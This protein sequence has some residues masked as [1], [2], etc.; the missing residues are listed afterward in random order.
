MDLPELRYPEGDRA[1]LESDD[2]EDILAKP[3]SKRFLPFSGARGVC[4]SIEPKLLA[5]LWPLREDMPSELPGGVL[6]GEDMM[7]WAS[8]ESWSG[9]TVEGRGGCGQRGRRDEGSDCKSS[10]AET[11]ASRRVEDDRRHKSVPSGSL[12]RSG[13]ILRWWWLL[14]STQQRPRRSWADRSGEARPL[15]D[16]ESK[17]CGGSWSWSRRGS[18]GAEMGRRE[19]T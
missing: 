12:C 14:P 6:K 16:G 4:G 19:A 8:R 2:D 5:G 11:R 9:R 1:S 17:R 18:C 7:D 3:R 13:L 10:E 15:E